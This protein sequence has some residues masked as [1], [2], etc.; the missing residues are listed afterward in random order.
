MPHR[1]RRLVPLIVVAFALL[2]TANA[3]A[4]KK[5]NCDS[6]VNDTAATLLPCIMQDDLTGYMNDFWDIAVA[7]PGPDGH[8]SRNS[9]ESG[10]RASVMYVKNLMDQWGYQT[11][12]Q[13]YEFP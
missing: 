2:A 10:Y 5:P 7:N 3:S 4:A 12:V 1:L 11:T 8:P 9:G 6:Q 13:T